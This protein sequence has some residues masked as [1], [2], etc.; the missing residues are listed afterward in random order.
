MQ[1]LKLIII[2]GIDYNWLKSL[3][4]I[5]DCNLFLSIHRKSIIINGI[6]CIIVW[7][8]LDFSHHWET[9]K[10]NGNPCFI[11][12]PTCV[13]HNS[14]VLDHRR[15]FNRSKNSTIVRLVD[16]SII[17][18]VRWAI[19]RSSMIKNKEIVRDACLLRSE[20]RMT[21]GFRCFPMMWAIWDEKY[22]RWLM[23]V[24]GRST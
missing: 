13:S 4:Q 10:T 2:V 19:K 20:P 23:M 12:E 7:L 6:C 11:S 17:Y 24:F 14:L 22:V 1:Q 5:I 9:V 21:I 18:R 3:G 8:F 15:M 16:A